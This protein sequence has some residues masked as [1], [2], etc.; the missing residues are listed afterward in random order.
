MT[1]LRAAY[2][3]PLRLRQ[4]HSARLRVTFQAFN[5]SL[6]HGF[7]MFMLLDLLAVWREAQLLS[8]V[9]SAQLTIKTLLTYKRQ[10]LYCSL[11]QQVAGAGGR[12]VVQHGGLI[13]ATCVRH[14]WQLLEGCLC[15]GRS[16][17]GQ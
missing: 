4:K 17:S 14:T 15:T 5:F 8:N 13:V 1:P 9:P 3:R 11:Q 2:V 16:S 6:E 12:L 10:L 7:F